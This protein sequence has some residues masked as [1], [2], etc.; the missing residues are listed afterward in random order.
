MQIA[1]FAVG[2]RFARDARGPLEAKFRR[3]LVT[4]AHDHDEA[5]ERARTHFTDVAMSGVTVEY[6][7][8]VQLADT[9]QLESLVRP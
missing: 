8:P 9:I 1:M 5:L 3:V 6:E 2:V 4:L 7:R